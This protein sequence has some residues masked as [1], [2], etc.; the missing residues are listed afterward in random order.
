M[1]LSTSKANRQKFN[2]KKITLNFFTHLFDFPFTVLI[3][4]QQLCFSTILVKRRQGS[5]IKDTVSQTNSKENLMISI[6]IYLTTFLF[7]QI[8]FFI[9]SLLVSTRSRLDIVKH[10]NINRKTMMAIWNMEILCLIKAIMQ[11][12]GQTYFKETIKPKW[13]K[14]TLSFPADN[15]MI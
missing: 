4:H 2:F 7:P 12:A 13:I 11:Y 10:I 5:A 1:Q 14:S 15:V 9:H 8:F 6:L 3:S